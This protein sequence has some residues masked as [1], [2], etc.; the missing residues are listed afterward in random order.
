MSDNLTLGEFIESDN[1]IT[2]FVDIGIKTG[3]DS[4]ASRITLYTDETH[5]T[6]RRIVENGLI[7]NSSNSHLTNSFEN[8]KVK[9]TASGQT[10]AGY[11]TF[12]PFKQRPTILENGK[13]YAIIFDIEGNPS[14]NADRI[15]FISSDT[16]G[17]LYDPSTA[18]KNVAASGSNL[19]CYYIFTADSTI[20][21]TKNEFI[22][23]WSNLTGAN[24]NIYLLSI[25]LYCIDG[26]TEDI[27]ILS[28]LKGTSLCETKIVEPAEVLPLKFEENGVITA[29]EF[30]EA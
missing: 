29:A 28:K 23:G 8:R 5:T 4:V 3:Q 7:L 25:Q 10:G 12:N 17:T 1:N 13:R 21:N 22:F 19:N 9:I 15:G 6:L 30:I 16:L 11:F 20:I 18:S 14:I 27:N 2:P 26:L 24:I